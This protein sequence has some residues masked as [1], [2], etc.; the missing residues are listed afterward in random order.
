MLV[1]VRREDADQI[2]EPI[3]DDSVPKH[4]KTYMDNLFKEEKSGVQI[5]SK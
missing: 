2:F 3:S 5:C 4:L 1:Y